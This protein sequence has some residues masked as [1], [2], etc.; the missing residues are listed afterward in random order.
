MYKFVTSF[1]NKLSFVTGGFSVSKIV[2]VIG[3]VAFT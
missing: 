3:D 2:A 1:F